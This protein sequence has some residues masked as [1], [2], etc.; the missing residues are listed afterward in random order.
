MKQPTHPEAQYKCCE[1]GDVN[2]KLSCLQQQ[3]GQEH[4]QLEDTS[5]QQLGQDW[6][7]CGNQR[8]LRCEQSVKRPPDQSL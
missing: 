8:G 2:T 7:A 5:C 1:A 4:E 3:V 6:L